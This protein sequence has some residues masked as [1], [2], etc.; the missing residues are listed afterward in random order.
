MLILRAILLFGLSYAL[1]EEDP[2]LDLEEEPPVCGRDPTL[3]LHNRSCQTI[4]DARSTLR[5][6]M[7]Q[8]DLLDD[9]AMAEGA[10]RQLV[11]KLS[12]EDLLELNN[13]VLTGASQWPNVDVGTILLR[14]LETKKESS[15]LPNP[16][17]VSKPH[18]GG[19]HFNETFVI[20]FQVLHFLF[21]ETDAN[22][23]ISSCWSCCPAACYCV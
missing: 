20:V 1:V 15:A 10:E 14:S 22:V 18:L 19:D 4:E 23:K 21:H 11:L 12:R 9:N 16:G 2:A 13:F 5:N 8:L 3:L 17:D 7:L 6:V